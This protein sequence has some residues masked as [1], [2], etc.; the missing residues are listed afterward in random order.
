[1]TLD[2]L[3]ISFGANLTSSFI[4]DKLKNFFQKQSKPSISEVRQGTWLPSKY[5]RDH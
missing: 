5:K 3:L 4:Y 1:M 2:S